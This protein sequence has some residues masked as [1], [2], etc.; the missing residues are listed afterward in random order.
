[1]PATLQLSTYTNF[2]DVVR[3]FA[4]PKIPATKKVTDVR[5]DLINSTLINIVVG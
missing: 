4:P 1:M 3:F 2:L 5:T